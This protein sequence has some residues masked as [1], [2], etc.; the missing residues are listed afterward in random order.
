MNKAKNLHNTTPVV[1]AHLDLGGIIYNERKNGKTNVI[2]DFYL[3]D[4][5]KTGIKLV[6]AAIFIE[7]E[8]L[9]MAL[10]L[11]LRQINAIKNDVKECSGNFKMV[12][13]K[14][15]L[16]CV[17]NSDKIGI[18]LSLEGAEPLGLDIE[19][20]ESFYELGIR[21]LG[22]VWS[23]RN[24]VADGSYF[25]NPVEGIRG[26][27]TP[28]GIS[29]IKEAKKIGM[30]LDVS[31]MNEQGFYDVIEFYDGKIM[32]SHSNAKTICDITRNLSDKQIKKISDNGG[33]IG[34]N[35]Y[36]SIVAA[37]EKSQTVSSICNHIEHII[38]TAN[39][40]AVGFGFD[41]CQRYYKNSTSKLDVLEN[42][43]Q[44]LEITEELL[45]R[46]IPERTIRKIL[47]LNFIKFVQSFLR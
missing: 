46:N 13:N 22:L 21:G 7:T 17:L 45:N 35:A 37:D 14:S 28:F 23:R 19:L 43:V 41:L 18:L 2:E 39:D 34:V 8:F 10:R 4:F 5:R 30:W 33:F 20:L 32:A 36:T 24:F 26:G 44:S 11:S 16:E 9:Q 25:R 12:Y 27:L 3:D 38:K 31:H 29:I 42:H 1:D 40:D 47:G 15:D 6:V